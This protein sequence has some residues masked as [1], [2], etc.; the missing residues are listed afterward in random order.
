[1]RRA[2]PRGLYGI[3]DS[4]FGDPVVTA[5][6]LAEAGC[7]TVQL[8]AKGWSQARVHDAAAAI[9]GPL[10]AL[11]TCFIINDHP[12]IARAVCADGVH[13]GEEDGSIAQARALL[14]PKMIIGWST[15]DLQAVS[16][17]AEADYIGFGPIFKTGSKA[18][19]L[20]P[21]G[22]G[23]LREA[24][25]M[26]PCPVVAIGGIS[27]QNIALVQATGVHGWACISA[28]LSSDDLSAAVARMRDG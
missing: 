12:G 15:H 23:M 27:T 22:L 19:A 21:R 9:S 25:A 26:A 6:H 8:R 1:M 28:L 14:G 3:A 20:P 17:A 13:L 10:S 16:A 2:L 24:A 11:G 7:D 18:S 4:S 5:I